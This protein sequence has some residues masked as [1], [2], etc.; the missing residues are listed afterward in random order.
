MDLRGS[1]NI[2]TSAAVATTSKAHTFPHPAGSAGNH[3]FKRL[4]RDGDRRFIIGGLSH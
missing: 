3:V 1:A 4:D 2:C